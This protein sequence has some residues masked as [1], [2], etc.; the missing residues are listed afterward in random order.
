MQKQLIIFT[1][2]YD[3]WYNIVLNMIVYF[4]IDI[5]KSKKSELYSFQKNFSFRIVYKTKQITKQV[6]LLN[7]QIIYFRCL[8][9]QKFSIIQSTK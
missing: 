6:T 4:Y 1:K 5:T 8:V 9:S 3:I 7:I 2:L